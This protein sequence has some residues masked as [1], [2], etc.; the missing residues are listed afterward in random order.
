MNRHAKEAF[1]K[2]PEGF[3]GVFIPVL[4]EELAEHVADRIEYTISE[5]LDTLDVDQVFPDEKKLPRKEL[6][7]GNGSSSMYDFIQ[8]DSETEMKFVERLNDDGNDPLFHFHS[9]NCI[10][11]LIGNYNLTG[12]PPME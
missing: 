7:V 6:V 11:K 10:P 5:D 2:N 3:A 12:N 4:R 1:I 8:C 9:Q